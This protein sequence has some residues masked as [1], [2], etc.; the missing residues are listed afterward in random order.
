[1]SHFPLVQ[2]DTLELLSSQPLLLLQLQITLVDLQMVH[3]LNALHPQCFDA[4]LDYTSALPPTTHVDLQEV[5]VIPLE[6]FPTP[7]VYTHDLGVESVD[8]P[9]QSLNSVLLV[10]VH[11]E[12][13]LPN[14]LLVLLHLF[15]LVLQ[16]QRHNEHRLVHQIVQLRLHGLP[17]LVQ[18]VKSFD[19]GLFNLLHLLLQPQQCLIIELPPL[20]RQSNQPDLLQQTSHL[21]EDVLLVELQIEIALVRQRIEVDTLEFLGSTLNGF[22]QQGQGRNRLGLRLHIRV[23]K[24]EF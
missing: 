6:P 19:L 17:Q 13:L 18:P 5:R 14:F 7:P 3:D 2:L 4:L 20:S 8:L 21:I 10:V 12:Q 22:E 11:T 15:D 16:L 23:D 24:T 9:L 1:M